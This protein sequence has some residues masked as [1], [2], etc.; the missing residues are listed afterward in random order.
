[1]FGVYLVLW[2]LCF[3]VQVWGSK[4]RR[5][6]L[7]LAVSVILSFL[8]FPVHFLFLSF[9]VPFSECGRGGTG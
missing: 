6:Y 2:R 8:C 7:P 4:A 1:M 3:S 9:S 5:S